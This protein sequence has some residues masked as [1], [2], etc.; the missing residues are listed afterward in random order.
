M[1]QSRNPVLFCVVGAVAL[2]LLGFLQKGISQTSEKRFIL[3]VPPG[4]ESAWEGLSAHTVPEAAGSLLLGGFKAIAVDFLWVRAHDMMVKQRGHHEVLA[5]TEAI[6]LLQPTNA[7]VLTHLGWNVSYNLAAREHEV[8]KKWKWVKEGIR[9]LERAAER[10]PTQHEIFA[11]LG[12]VYQHRIPQQRALVGQVWDWKGK[13]PFRLSFEYYQKSREVA[14][15]K[16]RRVPY[17]GTQM[18]ALEEH[19]FDALERQG[20]QPAIDTCLEAIEFGRKVTAEHI[21]PVPFWD[22]RVELQEKCLPALQLELEAER[23]VRR[24]PRAADRIRDDAY[25]IYREAATE[26]RFAGV[27]Y[28]GVDFRMLT[29]LGRYAEVAFS[30]VDQG[31]IV[32]AAQIL[33]TVAEEALSISRVVEQGNPQSRGANFWHKVYEEYEDLARTFVLYEQPA[34]DCLKQPGATAERCA[35][36]VRKLV[37]AWEEFLRVYRLEPR[38]EEAVLK[39]VQERLKA[40]RAT[41]PAAEDSR[42]TRKAT[43][44][45]G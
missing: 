36:A 42:E 19:V 16:G 37:E 20:A 44:L 21:T 43:P 29:L 10:N 7:D 3:G 24:D 27:R 41:L 45:G 13:G 15:A 40:W 17:D 11:D 9:F 22:K 28:Q 39:R 2:V 32:P 1:K 31:Q 26:P 12:H 30:Y 38:E 4:A 23:L 6:A 5:L 34:R 14:K 35:P 33:Q 25:R 8:D 18:H